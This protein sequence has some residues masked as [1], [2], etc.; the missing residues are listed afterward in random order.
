MRHRQTLR[1]VFAGRE[2]DFLLRVGEIGRLEIACGAGIGAVLQRVAIGQYGLADIRETVRL[3]LIGG[4][5]TSAEAE[6]L[7]SA[8]I[9]PCP[10]DDA[11]GLAAE[12]LAATLRHLPDADPKPRD[13]APQKSDPGAFVDALI[14]AGGAIGFT[15]V[16]INAMTLGEL[17]AVFKGHARANSPADASKAPSLDEFNRVLADESAKGNV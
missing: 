11:L 9:D 2:R 14:E 10:L 4:G 8:Y 7:V 15:P 16:D 3:G 1:R 17:A 5:A 12:I 13:E 6:S